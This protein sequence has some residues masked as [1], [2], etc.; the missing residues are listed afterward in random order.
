MRATF[1]NNDQPIVIGKISDSGADVDKK[2]WAFGELVQYG[3]EKFAALKPRVRI[4]RSTSTYK[5]ST[6]I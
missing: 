2:V 5:L 1:R 3:Q 4:V 6:M